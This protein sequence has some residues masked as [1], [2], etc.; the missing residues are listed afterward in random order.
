MRSEQTPSQTVGP[1]F[2]Y[3]LTPKQYG[4]NFS[5]LAGP[6]MVDGEIQGEHIRVIG[7]VLDGDGVPVPDAMIE[8]WT[9]DR[10][11]YHGEF[12][13]FAGIDAQPR[14]VQKPYPT[15]VVGGQSMPAY[16]RAVARGHAWYGFNLS[17]EQTAKCIEGLRRA[18]EQVERPAALGELG[19]IVTPPPGILGRAEV[20]RYAELGVGELAVLGMVGDADSIIAMVEEQA[21]VL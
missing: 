12:C 6:Q 16:R 21:K 8:V 15:L 18:A 4:Y 20:E 3:A 2:A 14:P 9:A 10:P 5:S 1:Y 19:L 13:G 11:E 17:V 7:Q